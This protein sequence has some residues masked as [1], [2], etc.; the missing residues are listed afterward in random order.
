MGVDA[1][2]KM[3]EGF[4]FMSLNNP[5]CGGQSPPTP[6]FRIQLP[7]IRTQKPELER[8]RERQ[9][10]PK[11]PVVVEVVR[12][13]PA[14]IS[15]TRPDPMVVPGAAPQHARCASIWPRWVALRRS[16]VIALVVPI[17]DPLPHVAS[18]V[19][20]AVWTVSRR[21]VRAHRCGRVQAVRARREQMVYPPTL[22]IVVGVQLVPDEPLRAVAALRVPLVAPGIDP[23]APGFRVPACRFLSFGLCRQPQP[24]PI[25]I[26]PRVVP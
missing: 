12:I 8:K 24:G 6:P 13:A 1:L 9:A 7:E 11:T 19:R 4:H 14:A 20:A 17:G 5:G 18:H 25:A 2:V 21:A 22:P 3:F 26:G 15:G 16:P 23:L 10:Y